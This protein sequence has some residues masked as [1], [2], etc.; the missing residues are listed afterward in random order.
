MLCL[1]ANDVYSG[2]SGSS[3]TSDSDT[4]DLVFPTPVAVAAKVRAKGIFKDEAL[5][6][7]SYR[8]FVWQNVRFQVAFYF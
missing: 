2:G 7:A 4:G 1:H 5:G 6:N 8:H 3:Q